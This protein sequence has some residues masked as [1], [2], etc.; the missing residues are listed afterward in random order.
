MSKIKNNPILQKV[1]GMLGETIVFRRGPTGPV[2]ANAPKKPESLHANQVAARDRFLDAVQYAKRQTAKDE[3]KAMYATGISRRLPSAY[4]V[5]VTDYLSVPK[6]KQIDADAYQGG[7][8]QVINVHASDD[9]K[10]DSVA[11]VIKSA[12]GEEIE[13]GQAML[14]ED[15]RD[16]WLYTTTSATPL[17]AGTTVTVSVRDIPGN[18]AIRTLT[19]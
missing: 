7:P 13:R 6:I 9:F 5:A 2:M 11:V 18:L 17:L 8:G 19:L 16:V 1:T 12:A 3:V 10:V 14:T 4:Q 15:K